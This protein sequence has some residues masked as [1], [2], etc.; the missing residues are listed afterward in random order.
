V[1]IIKKKDAKA[2][3]LDFHGWRQFP[4]AFLSFLVLFSFFMEN[5][6]CGNP[7]RWGENSINLS[8]FLRTLRPATN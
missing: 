1:E 7:K 5:R 8:R 6:L 3:D 4:Q 2:T